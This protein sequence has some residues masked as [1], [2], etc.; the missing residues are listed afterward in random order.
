MSRI[1]ACIDSSPYA[2]SVCALAGWTAARLSLPVE[3]LHVVQR[4]DAVAARRDLSGAIGLGVKRE[5][6][7]ELT[8]IDEAEG[9]LAIERGRILL[10][11]AEQQLRAAGVTDVRQIHRHGGIVETI[12]EREEDADLV[13]M[14]KRGASGAF[15]A[16]HLGSKVERVVR[17]SVKPVLIASRE[18]Q[19]PEL[20]VIAFDGSPAAGRA[21]NYVAQSPLFLDM[22]IHLV[23]AGRDDVT[24]RE[25]LDRAAVHFYGNKKPTIHVADGSPEDVIASYMAQHPQ[26]L[27]VMGAYGHSPLRTLIVGSTT[28]AMVRTVATPILLLR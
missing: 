27:L 4:N 6:L 8:R 21:V 14:G 16:D 18:F 2:A 12:I 22:D 19:P 23:S 25:R 7:E 3:V 17:S 13:V 1:L 10:A 11:A 24:H 5:L 15:A 9:R 26:G 28:T 20:A